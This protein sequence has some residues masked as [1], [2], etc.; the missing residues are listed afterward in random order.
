MYLSV[1]DP[2]IS[3]QLLR[4]GVREPAMTRLIQ[5]EIRPGMI[6]VDVGAN[7]GYYA[8]LEARLVGSG[9]R[10]YA[11]DPLPENVAI[12]NK[13]IQLNGYDNLTVHACA[14]SDRD[15]RGTLFRSKASNL[16]SM[17]SAAD[18]RL[19]G[20]KREAQS[21]CVPTEIATVT[22][23]RFIDEYR[24][25][26]VDF[27]RMD[28]EG[29]EIAATSGMNRTFTRA[30][31]PLKLFIEVHNLMFADPVN[32]IGPWL[33]ELLRIGFRPDALVVG[34]RLQRQLEPSTFVATLCSYRRS[35]PQILLVKD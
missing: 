30:K 7:L 3:R 9:G 4:Y 22:L 13:S 26:Q 17:L 23:D 14:V 19:E 18:K 8:L 2:G 5:G 15:G 1:S 12:L 31:H 25:P 27:I 20:R 16:G 21:M 34:D 6:G 10:I 11:I 33:E 35:C 24:V 32:V 29:G 28:I